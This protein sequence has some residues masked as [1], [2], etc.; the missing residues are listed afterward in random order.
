MAACF[1][2]CKKPRLLPVKRP[3][4]RENRLLQLIR[5]LSSQHTGKPVERFFRT[6]IQ[7]IDDVVAPRPHNGSCQ[8]KIIIIPQIFG[9]VDQI[10]LVCHLHKQPV[11]ALVLRKMPDHAKRRLIVWK[12]RRRV[13][14]VAVV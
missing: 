1:T 2:V 10:P 13:A 12:Q 7:G 3:A 9:P 14:G 4:I 6:E 11:R 5:L 8:R